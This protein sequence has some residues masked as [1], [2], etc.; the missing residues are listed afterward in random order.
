MNYCHLYYN[1][2]KVSNNIFRMD[3]FQNKFKD[4]YCN[5]IHYN[6]NKD[7]KCHY[8]SYGESVIINGKRDIILKQE[9]L[10]YP[11]HIKGCL[12]Y[13]KEKIYD[14]RNGKLITIYN[15]IICGSENIIIEHRYN[16]Y[17]KEH[18]LPLGI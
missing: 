11:N 18:I 5:I 2:K 17:D 3:S 4:G 9:S 16:F 8:F 10:K 14:L 13:I 15:N 7:K 12:S 6:R 1:N